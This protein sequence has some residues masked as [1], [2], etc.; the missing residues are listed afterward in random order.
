M[1]RTRIVPIIA[2]NGVILRRGR[3]RYLPVYGARCRFCLKGILWIRKA[4]E[5]GQLPIDPET[6]D[7]EDWYIAKKH[8]YHGRRC[9]EMREWQAHHS[10]RLGHTDPDFIV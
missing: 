4:A 10:K 6:W 1:S 8:R 2:D 5:K 9:V 7:G 3:W